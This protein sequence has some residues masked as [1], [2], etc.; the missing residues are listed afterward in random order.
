M[1][2]KIKKAHEFDILINN[3]QKTIAN[4]HYVLKRIKS[5]DVDNTSYALIVSKKVSNKAHDR[6]YVRRRIK[7]VIRH[8]EDVFENGYIYLIIAR[9]SLLNEE[10]KTFEK[11]FKHILKLSNKGGK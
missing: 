4:Y 5:T 11:S 9:K 1:L 3:K 10:Y 8:N 7:E 6:H 2:K